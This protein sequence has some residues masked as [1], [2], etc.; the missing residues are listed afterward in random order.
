M[1]L[2]DRIV[3]ALRASP[4][5]GVDL[6]YLDGFLVRNS[7]ELR[8]LVEAHTP[9]GRWRMAVWP[10]QA[11]FHSQ[12][13]GLTPEQ[14][15][16]GHYARK[17]PRAWG[18]AIEAFND[19]GD[20]YIDGVTAGDEVL[21]GD[22]SLGMLAARLRPPS[23]D[24]PGTFILDDML[25]EEARAHAA[26]LARTE[27]AKPSWAVRTGSDYISAVWGGMMLDP[28]EAPEDA[29][30]PWRRG[31]SGIYRPPAPPAKKARKSRSRARVD[32]DE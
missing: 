8:K 14:Q 30:G 23:P 11:P 10:V 32:D 12:H 16:A 29:W 9:R 27:Y 25:H 28:G 15:A 24:G 21:S 13:Y 6:E 1:D 3:A 4:P 17:D 31:V 22:F 5:A 18:V 19:T 20:G 26:R 2:Y 7:V